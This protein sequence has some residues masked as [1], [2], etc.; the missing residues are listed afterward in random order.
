MDSIYWKCHL[1]K[2]FNFPMYLEGNLYI[3]KKKNLFSGVFFF[4]FF[5]WRVGVFCHQILW[6]AKSCQAFKKRFGITIIITIIYLFVVFGLFSKSWILFIGKRHKFIE[7]F[8]F[9]GVFGGYLI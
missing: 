7:S 1:G 4:F 8:Q 3:Q 6:K 2:N 9:S 5:F